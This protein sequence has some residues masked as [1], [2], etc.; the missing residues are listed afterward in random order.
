MQSCRLLYL[1]SRERERERE[2]KVMEIRVGSQ[3]FEGEC[4]KNKLCGR[5]PQYAPPL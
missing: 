2:R 1:D 5:P 4:R 3:K